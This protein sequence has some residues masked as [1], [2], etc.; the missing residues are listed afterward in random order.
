MIVTTFGVEGTGSIREIIRE[1][2]T[3]YTLPKLTDQLENN[4]YYEDDCYAD[5]DLFLLEK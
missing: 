5:D 4:P 2:V 1:S 3:R